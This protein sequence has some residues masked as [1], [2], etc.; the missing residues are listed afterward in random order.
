M[1]GSP[2]KRGGVFLKTAVALGAAREI[3][4]PH[5]GIRIQMNL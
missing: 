1:R 4:E 2:G 5:I 3:E